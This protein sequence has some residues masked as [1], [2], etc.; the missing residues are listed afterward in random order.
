MLE[1]KRDIN[2]NLR[3]LTY[4]FMKLYRLFLAQQITRKIGLRCFKKPGPCIIL[5]TSI[6]VSL[7]LL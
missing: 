6:A 2:W 5:V 3:A 7:N 4:I 1:L